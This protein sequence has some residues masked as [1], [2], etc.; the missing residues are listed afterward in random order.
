MR[1]VRAWKLWLSEHLARAQRADL[2]L[3]AFPCGGHT[4]TGGML[5]AG[6]PVLTYAG[7]T[8]ASRVAGSA[9][10]VAGLP[11]L[12]T[13]SLEE[14]EALAVALARDPQRLAALRARL[15]ANRNTAL[16]FDM[17]R[18]ALDLEALYEAM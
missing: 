14:Y 9:L 8:F 17:R 2:A 4:T 11:E 15:Q 12:V 10:H 3:G 1:L 5:L 16:F 13:T 18:L 7:E 6:V